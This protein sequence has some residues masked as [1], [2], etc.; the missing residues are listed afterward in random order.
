MALLAERLPADEALAAGLVS[1]VYSP[2]AFDA[3]VAEV[4][5]TLTSGPAV[6]LRKTKQAINA[7]TL[8]G[9][10]DALEF[11]TAG[12]LELLA[13]ADFREGAKAFQQRRPPTFTDH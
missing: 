9:L 5:A 4:L 3:G 2:D 1:A 13:A 10:G 8:S 11:E 6:A 12:Q 7:A